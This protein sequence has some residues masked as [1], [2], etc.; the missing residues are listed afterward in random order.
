LITSQA[1]RIVTHLERHYAEFDGLNLTVGNIE[2]L[3]KHNGA[4]LKENLPWLWRPMGGSNDLELD[5]FASAEAQG[6]GDCR[7]RG[8]LTHHDCMTGCARSLFFR[9]MNLAELPYPQG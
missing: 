7:R 2:G 8:L 4:R 3:A 6:G 1:I 5:T 9:R